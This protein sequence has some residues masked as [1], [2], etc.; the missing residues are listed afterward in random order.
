LL[1]QAV[2]QLIE[3]KKL[4]PTHLKILFHTDP[5]GMQELQALGKLFNISEILDIQG[6]IPRQEILPI[7]YQSSILLVL[8]TLSTPNGTH[9]IMGT[10]FFENIGVEKPILCVQSD[11]ECLAHAIRTTQAGL[12]ANNVKDTKAFIL[13]KYHEWKQNGY[14]RQLVVNKEQF[15]RQHEA[16]QFEQLFIE[17]L[18]LRNI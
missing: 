5:K 14:T 3:E 8:T 2:S 7:M 1:F 12:A 15:T 17:T 10:K 9:G 11:E 6:Y 18:K 4:D 13:E 16:A